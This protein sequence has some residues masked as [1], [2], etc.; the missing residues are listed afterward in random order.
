MNAGNEIYQVKLKIV[1]MESS[2][3]FFDNFAEEGMLDL[4][5]DS[6]ELFPKFREA[7]QNANEGESFHLELAPQDAYGEHIP[8]LVKQ[9]ES[10]LIPDDLKVIDTYADFTLDDG[11]ILTGKIVELQDEHVLVDFNSPLSN[12]PVAIDCHLSKVVTL[13]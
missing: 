12:K 13:D 7:L 11:S 4:D 10:N 8:D 2:E 6:S 5:V 1:D 9:V 3:V